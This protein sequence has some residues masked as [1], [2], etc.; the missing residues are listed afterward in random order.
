MST[1]ELFASAART[2]TAN[3]NAFDIDDAYNCAFYLSVTAASGTTPTL[4]VK[5]QAYDPSSDSWYDTGVAFAQATGTT[6]ERITGALA[7]DKLR[8]VATI[9][10][11][12]PSFTFSVRAFYK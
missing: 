11:T 9:G 2:S 8:A 7:E 5:I 6:T 12:T 4:D 10:G 3:G 1:Q